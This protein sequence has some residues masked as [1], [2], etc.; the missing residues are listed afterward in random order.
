MKYE[1]TSI[2]VPMDTDL[3]QQHWIGE[4]DK[5]GAEGWEPFAVH[6]WD[7]F[8]QLRAFAL[9][10]PPPPPTNIPTVII[11]FRRVKPEE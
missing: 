1:I 11:W 4:A 3:Y 10:L 7:P 2:Q 9:P 8:Q 6:R 5:L